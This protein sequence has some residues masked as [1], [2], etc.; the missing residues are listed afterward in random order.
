MLTEQER[1]QRQKLAK[2][3]YDA[4]TVQFVFRFRKGADADIIE[5]LKGMPAKTDYIRGLIREDMT[6]ETA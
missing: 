4:K 1:V 5:R 3:R 6:R 2:A